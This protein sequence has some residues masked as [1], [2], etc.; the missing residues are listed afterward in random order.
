MKA[1]VVDASIWV[2]RLVEGDAF[3]AL[4]RAWLDEQRRAGTTFL[5]PAL[6]LVEVAAAISRRTG[7]PGLAKR[8]F[9]ALQHLP[10]LRLVAMDTSLVQ[11]AADLA[12]ALGVRGADAFYIA[13]AHQL[14]VPL[15]T[16]DADQAQRAARLLQVLRPN[17]PSGN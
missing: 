10:H 5:A 3:H 9:Q 6:L 7:Q 13:T 14:G 8:A 17:S 15:A 16:F 2:A 1:I 12:A 11:K 4:S